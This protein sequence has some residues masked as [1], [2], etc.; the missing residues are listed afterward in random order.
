MFDSLIIIAYNDYGGV[1]IVSERQFEHLG[2][3][4]KELDVH[5]LAWVQINMKLTLSH[6]A[7]QLILRLLYI[8]IG[9]L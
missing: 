6:N 9:P 5:R 2:Y 1:L 4:R 8:K 7:T 3:L